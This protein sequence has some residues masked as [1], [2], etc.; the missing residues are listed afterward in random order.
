MTTVRSFLAWLWSLL[1]NTLGRLPDNI[2]TRGLVPV[3]LSSVGTEVLPGD[4]LLSRD[5]ISEA[6]VFGRLQA[7]GLNL[8]QTLEHAFNTSP[9]GNIPDWQPKLAP[10][11]YLCVRGTHALEDGKKFE[12]FEITGVPDFMGNP[13]KGILFHHGNWDRDSFGCV[14]TGE[15]RLF[16]TGKPPMI[17][18]SD[19][20]FKA[21]MNSMVGIDQFWITVQ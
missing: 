14:L 16:P 9:A 17:T 15:H 18:S 19:I 5:D 7:P 2:D 6:G 21:F 20:A 1:L 13:V 12:T 11:R 8:L 3:T 4:V 10:G